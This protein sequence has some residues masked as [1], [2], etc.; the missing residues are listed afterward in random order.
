M[1]YKRNEK[2]ELLSQLRAR[3]N[4]LAVDVNERDKKLT[5]VKDAYLNQSFEYRNSGRRR[6]FGR[7]RGGTSRPYHMIGSYN[8]YPFMVKPRYQGHPNFSVPGNGMWRRPRRK[9]W[10]GGW[11]NNPV[12]PKWKYRIP[13][14]ELK[15][16][17]NI[18]DEEWEICWNFNSAK[19]CHRGS[20]C[21]WR[22]AKYSAAFNHPI[23]REPLKTNKPF[24]LTTAGRHA[25]QKTRQQQAPDV[26]KKHDDMKNSET[27]D[28]ENKREDAESEPL[29]PLNSQAAGSSNSETRDRDTDTKEVKLMTKNLGSKEKEPIAINGT[30]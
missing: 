15:R 21:S 8:S 14:S 5:D 18:P 25:G 22:H 11:N 23:T 12:P 30:S 10:N 1:N 29:F 19:G 27:P 26:E 13:D 20:R 17:S 16:M 7:G 28:V 9:V 24:R 3:L 2:N 6:G 4:N